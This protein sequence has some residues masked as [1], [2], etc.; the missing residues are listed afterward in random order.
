MGGF[1]VGKK[2]VDL[3]N[4]GWVLEVVFFMFVF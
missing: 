4:K 2:I 1:Q 3:G